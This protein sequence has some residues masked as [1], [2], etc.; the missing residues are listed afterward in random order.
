MELLRYFVVGRL[1]R[2]GHLPPEPVSQAVLE[3]SRTAVAELALP[4]AQGIR[5]PVLLAQSPPATL[6]KV[7]LFVLQRYIWSR[8]PSADAAHFYLGRTASVPSQPTAGMAN[9]TRPKRPHFKYSL[10]GK[11][12]C[13]SRWGIISHHWNL[14]GVLIKY[15]ILL[16][17]LT[18]AARKVVFS[19]CARSAPIT[20]THYS[21]TQ[22]AGGQKVCF[23]S[24]GQD[25][26]EIP[27]GAQASQYSRGAQL[28]S[29]FTQQQVL[30][31]GCCEWNEPSWISR[32]TAKKKH[33]QAELEREQQTASVAEESSY[34][35]IIVATVFPGTL[36]S[37]RG[38]GDSC[39]CA[40]HQPEACYFPGNCKLHSRT[41]IKKSLHLAIK[42]GPCQLSEEQDK[43]S[44]V[45][46][47]LGSSCN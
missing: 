35:Y 9:S 19:H 17:H 11:T 13:R 18:I 32:M 21:G 23:C 41:E 15:L 29:H 37:R 39:C 20:E 24:S 6:G 16:H 2:I 43:V 40:D 27:H 36:L 25:D 4:T 12:H 30:L 1:R 26:G 33:L 34:R 22:P 14:F 7:W 46:D 3:L 38:D 28:S 8:R 42:P 10:L 31:L 5:L 45:T 44:K 47:W